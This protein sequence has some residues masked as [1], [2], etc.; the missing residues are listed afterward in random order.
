MNSYIHRLFEGDYTLK[1]VQLQGEVSN[2]KYHSSGH[3]YF[4][5]K[6]ER[7]QI[8]C[9]MFARDRMQGLPFRLENGQSVIAGGNVS[10][11]E[12]GGSYQLYVRKI[13]LSG[14][15]ELYLRFEKLKRELYEK[16]YFDF[17]KKKPLPRF[18]QK[19]GIVTAS[20]GA[21]IRDIVSVAGR[22]NPF[23][24]L[25]LYPA[26]VQGEGAALSIA[27]G[28]RYLDRFGVDVI[29]IGRG[30]GSI[31]DLWAFNEIPV[32]DA[33][34]EARTPIISGT[35]HEI[36]TTIADYCAD[37]RAATPSAACEMAVPDIETI[38]SA[39][40]NMQDIM[41]SCLERKVRKLSGQLDAYAAKLERYR[42][43][44]RLKTW[45]I[46]LD[47][48]RDQLAA[49]MGKKVESRKRSYDLCLEKLSLLSPTSRLK[50]GYS[51]AQGKGGEPFHSVSQL[52]IGERFDLVFSDGQA[53]VEPV[54]IIRTPFGT[55]KAKEATEKEN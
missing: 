32:A 46:Q 55:A 40:D 53:E 27:S 28:I 18:P 14:T 19:I 43:E 49:S 35:G 1:R 50:G 39:M 7:S 13:R 29:I 17:E 41:Q 31:E 30:G 8:R 24:Q 4:S 26:R 16:G 9:V 3:L 37:V 34:Y 38:F 33:I 23:V 21:A 6:D 20:T 47:H 5:L 44:H 36:D 48:L 45:R 54:R 11:Y 10:V 25:Y 2:C 42:P 52:A 51:F 22:R 15:G 12:Q